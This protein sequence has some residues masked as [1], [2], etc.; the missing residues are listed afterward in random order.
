MV[1]TIQTSFYIIMDIETLRDYCLRKHAVKECFPFDDTTLVFKVLNRMF[2]CIDLNHAEQAS[3]KCDPDYALE[4]REQ[5]SGIEGAWHFNKKHWN[6]VAL[7]L[8]IPD[9]LILHLIDHSYEQV[10]RKFT[11]KEKELYHALS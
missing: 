10:I 2:L 7:H 6:Q 5:Y 4:L 8:D 3:M 11:R 1:T 9:S